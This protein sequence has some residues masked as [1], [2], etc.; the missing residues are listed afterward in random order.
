V[1]DHASCPA[2]AGIAENVS[3]APLTS[4]ELGGR[5]RYYL[6]AKDD[7]SVASALAWAREAG[8]PAIVLGGG[9]NVVVADDGVDALVIRLAQRGIVHD[10]VVPG[11]VSAAA[12]EPWDPFVERMVQANLAGLECLSGIPG[13]VGATPIQNVG[14]YGQEV[15]DTLES[16]RVLDRETLEERVFAAAEC[17]LGYR[18][19][20]FRHAQEFVVLGVTFRLEPGGRP[21]LRYPELQRAVEDDAD[22]RPTLQSVRETVL[23]LRAGKSMVIRPDDPNRRSAG[24]FFVNPIV[25][26]EEAEEV[27]RRA[28]AAGVV[29]TPDQVPAFPAGEEGRTKLSAGW[30]VDHGGFSKGTRRGPVGI[31]SAHALALV[32]HGGG[33]AADLVRLAREVRSGVC[34]RFGVTLR[35]EPV[36]LGFDGGDPLGEP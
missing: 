25:T 32:H 35:P 10:P 8:V 24:S 36:F 11:R 27:R 18:S 13:T 31:S 5:A 21:T 16:V 1:P 33:T 7:D 12:G 9:S 34:E 17:D 14:A 22:G 29:E 26:D 30:L 2:P 3:L 4:L 15:S 23:R 6:E 19:S 20:R 28:V